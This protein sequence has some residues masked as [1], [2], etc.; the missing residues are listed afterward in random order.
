MEEELIAKKEVL[1]QTRISYGQFYRWKRKGLIPESWFI[2]K[3][4]FTGQ[5]TFLPKEKILERIAKIK[6]LKDRYSLDELAKLFSPELTETG[7]S[8]EEIERMNWLSQEVRG[9]YDATRRAK[10]P[11]S[12]KELLYLAVLERLRQEGLAGEELE[13]ASATLSA[14]AIELKEGELRRLAIARKEAGPAKPTVVVSLCLIFNECLF[15]PKTEVVAQVELNK[16]LEELKLKLRG[17]R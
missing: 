13:L 10:G 6:E 9:H 11:Y 16:V 12:F 8:S 2:R 4:T 14:H 15:D 1:E 17:V 7:F 5:E 3:S